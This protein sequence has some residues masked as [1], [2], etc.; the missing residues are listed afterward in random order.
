MRALG[1]CTVLNLVMF[2]ALVVL[3]AANQYVDPFERKVKQY[4]P[5]GAVVTT[6]DGRYFEFTTWE[7]RYVAIMFRDRP[8]VRVIAEVPE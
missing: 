1:I 3:Y 2:V 7:G 6:R 8:A 5:T 4:L